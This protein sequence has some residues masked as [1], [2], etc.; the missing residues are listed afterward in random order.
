[1]RILRGKSSLEVSSHGFAL[2]VVGLILATFV[3]G[4]VRTLLGSDRVH[5]RIV[6][7]LRNRFPKQDIK[8]GATEVLLSRGIW[9]ALGLKIT[10]VSFKQETCDRLSFSLEVPTAVLP[11]NLWSLKSGNVRLGELELFAGKMHFDYRPCPSLAPP[12]VEIKKPKSPLGLMLPAIV[13]APLPPDWHPPKFEWKDW[14]RALDGV[15]LNDFTLTYE[16]NPTW[17]LFVSSAQLDFSQ[18]FSGRASVEVQKSLPF[19]TLIHLVEMDAHSDNSVLQ[20]QINSEFKEGRVTW[21]GSWDT[22][23]HSAVSSVEVSQFPIKEVLTELFQMGLIDREVEMKTTWVSCNAS[24]E[25]SFK[26][27]HETPVQI[28]SCKLEGAYGGMQLEKADL[29]PF[30]GELL[31][32]PMELKVQNLQVQPIVEALNRQVLPTVINK[33]GVWSGQVQ[34]LNRNS[35]SLNGNLDGGEVVFSNQSVRGKQ[36]LRRIHTTVERVQGLIAAK[37]DQV[38]M[39]DGQFNGVV[40]FTLND[41]WR[42]GTF[43]ADIANLKLSPGIQVLLMGGGWD[44]LRLNGNGALQNGELS[45]WKGTFEAPKLNGVGWSG[46]NLQVQ[47]KYAPG[48]FTMEAQLNRIELGPQWRYFPMMKERVGQEGNTIAVKDVR[49]KV[50]VRKQGGEILS[51]TAIDEVSGKTWRGRGTW[52]RDHELVAALS[53][54][55][56]GKPRTYTVRAEKGLLS[57]DEQPGAAR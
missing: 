6:M 29:Y 22:N 1:M 12:P 5:Q 25:G 21:K 36:S 30:Y 31:K 42:S 39:N 18:E 50:E 4:A 34:Y 44:T 19:G 57:M 38:E 35:W 40:E 2:F 43:R 26:K 23:N 49:T 41:D 24:W 48:V 45:E 11:V 27:P 20:W 8:I 7:E 54:T 9:P 15:E 37:I 53:G 28:K 3:G 13:V 52:L 47:S 17:K 32:Q 55:V 14:G 46:D 16:N 51:F 56:A 33:L 10:S